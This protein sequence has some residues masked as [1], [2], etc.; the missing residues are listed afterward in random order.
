MSQTILSTVGQLYRSV[1]LPLLNCLGVFDLLRYIKRNSA[2]V[3]MYHGVIDTRT[4]VPININQVDLQSF[5]WQ[6]RF[7][8]DHYN[9]VPLSEIVERVRNSRPVSELAAITLDDGYRSVV[10]NAAPLLVK[11]ALP[12]TIFLITG[13]MDTE[14][15]TWY[16]KAEAHFLN[17]KSSEID[18]GGVIYQIHG[19]PE[20][21]V[22]A[23]KRRLKS[24]QLEER[25]ALLN[26]LFEKAGELEPEAEEP[27]RLMT[28]TEAEQLRQQGFD[29]GVHSRSHP[30]LTKVPPPDLDLEIDQPAKLIADR[31]GLAIDRL[32]F[33]YPDGDWNQRVRDRVIRAGMLGAVAVGQALVRPG[34]DAFALPRIHVMGDQTNTMFV[35]AV[36]ELNAWINKIRASVHK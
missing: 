16:D 24:M 23:F 36:V 5:D 2:L 34:S 14:E 33:S 12:A 7:L 6:L 31:L 30:H 15:I 22:K 17:I 1:G 32:I 3:L 11:Y 4:G 8:K 20:T 10:D 26:E 18:I 9:V 28:W 25:N 27:Y 13:I 35:E 21:T 29:F 19:Q